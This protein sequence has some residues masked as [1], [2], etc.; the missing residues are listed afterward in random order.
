MQQCD[1]GWRLQRIGNAPTRVVQDQDD[2]TLRAGQFTEVFQVRVHVGGT[3]RVAGRC[4]P[5][6]LGYQGW[7]GPTGRE[8]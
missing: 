3:D 5:W 8:A 6:R 7:S 1:V 2:M 4:V